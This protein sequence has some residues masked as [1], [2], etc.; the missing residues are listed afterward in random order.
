LADYRKL[1]YLVKHIQ[2]QYTLSS[3]I[4][5]KKSESIPLNIAAFAPFNPNKKY[6]ELPFSTQLM[7]KL[8]IPAILT[9]SF[10]FK[11]TM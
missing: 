6:A 9:T 11:L 2:L 7:D 5:Q 10:Q 4:Y 8:L 3:S 1:D